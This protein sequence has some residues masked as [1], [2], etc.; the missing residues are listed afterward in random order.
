MQRLV[1]LYCQLAKKHI[2]SYLLLII[3]AFLLMACKKSGSSTES[4]GIY[5]TWYYKEFYIS[6]GAPSFWQPVRETGQIVYFRNDGRYASNSV[7]CEYENFKLVDSKKILLTARDNTIR[8]QV[9]LFELDSLQSTLILYPLNPACIEG[10]GYKFS[11][12]K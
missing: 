12:M 2:R 6:P 7:Y 4:T 9:L 1:N 11:R 8:S 3:A 10:C 5:G